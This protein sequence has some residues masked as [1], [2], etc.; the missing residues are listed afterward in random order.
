MNHIINS[1]NYLWI[2]FLL[3][4]VL[5]SL[6][7][8]SKRSSNKSDIQIVTEENLAAGQ[9]VVA[10]C[11]NPVLES[12]TAWRAA[13]DRAKV[14]LIEIEIICSDLVQHR[15]RVEQR[16]SDIPGHTLPTWQA[17]IDREYAVWD[18]LHV[19]IDTALLSP[20]AAASAVER[21]I[22]R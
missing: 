8:K 11:V 15:H 6:V 5:L 13:A 22:N 20:D 2:G 18:R 1:L 9:L 16:L 17:V 21:L 19:V 7:V 14:R 3:L 10:D 12:R 4:G